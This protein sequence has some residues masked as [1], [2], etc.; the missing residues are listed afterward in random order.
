MT[1]DFELLKSI[2]EKI[3][4]L[5]WKLKTIDGKPHPFIDL[6][7]ETPPTWLEQ[8]TLDYLTDENLDSPFVEVWQDIK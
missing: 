6:L 1:E 8:I 4:S 5:D 7:N 2:V 3:A